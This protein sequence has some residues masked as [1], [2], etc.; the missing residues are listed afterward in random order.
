MRLGLLTMMASLATD[1]NIEEMEAEDALL[2]AA[3]GETGKGPAYELFLSVGNWKVSTTIHALADADKICGKPQNMIA[4]V[5][6]TNRTI[7]L[8]DKR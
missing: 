7:H 4:R 5:N 1:E 3:M 6:H 2:L 8:R